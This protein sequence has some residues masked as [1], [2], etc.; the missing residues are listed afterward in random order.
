MKLSYV[1]FISTIES[2]IPGENT[3]AMTY[4]IQ[5]SAGISIDMADNGWLTVNYKGKD[6]VGPVNRTWVYSPH[7]VAYVKVLGSED[8]SLKEA[9]PSKK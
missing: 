6:S 4:D 3:G 8:F 9:A 5:R 7:C 2:I 1:R